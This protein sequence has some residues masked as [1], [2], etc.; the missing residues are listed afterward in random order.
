MTKICES[1]LCTNLASYVRVLTVRGV[2]HLGATA[3]T[4]EHHAISY[5]SMEGTIGYTHLTFEEFEVLKIKAA[6]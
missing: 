1:K 5:L 4:C 6:L 2:H 3:Y